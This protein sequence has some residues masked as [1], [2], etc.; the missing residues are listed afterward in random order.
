[1][2]GVRTSGRNCG[3]RF[4]DLK[5]VTEQ[6]FERIIRKLV[7]DARA[8]EPSAGS[9]I[10]NIRFPSEVGKGSLDKLQKE[11]ADETQ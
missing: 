1:V 7:L 8:V 11:N 10:V 5:F 9:F 2:V 6:F 3:I 4:A